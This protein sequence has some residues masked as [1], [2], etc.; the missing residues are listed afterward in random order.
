[1]IVQTFFARRQSLRGVVLLC[2]LAG[3]AANAGSAPA[4]SSTPA[5][6]SDGG[7]VV[8]TADRLSVQ[9][10]IDRKVYT[11]AADLQSITGTVADVLQAVPSIELDIDGNL[12]L[13]GDSNVTVLVD[14]RPV[15]SLAGSSAADAL[16][17][18]PAQDIERIEVITNP[19]AQFKA[20][21]TAGI[22]NIV[23]KKARKDGHSGGLQAN[24]GNAH[25]WNAAANGSVTQ[26]RFTLSG[27]ASFREDVRERI[28]T[29]SRS[30]VVPQTGAIVQSGESLDETM[31]RQL[32]SLRGSIEFAI[33][34]THKLSFSATRGE[35][36]GR[37]FFDQYNTSG[38]DADLSSDTLRHSDGLEWSI[39][40]SQTLNYEQT[41]ARPEEKLT[42]SIGRTA[43]HER[44]SYLYT[45]TDLLSALPVTH[46]TLES[47]SDKIVYL[48]NVDYVL[49][50]SSH[51]K[52]KT[53]YALEDNHNGSDNGGDLEDP[54][55]GALLPNPLITNHFRYRQT[56]HAVYG[57][58]ESP[59]GAWTLLGGLRF[60]HT[61]VDISPYD[62]SPPTSFG[63][64]RPFPSL[65]I[66]RPVSDEATVSLS[67]SRRITRPDGYA[68]DPHV[69]RQDIHNLRAGNPLLRPQD[70]K[71]YE[72]AYAVDH[73]G[74]SYSVTGYWRDTHDSYTGITVPID[75]Q[76]TL[77]TLTNLPHSRSGGMEFTANGHLMPRLGYNLSGNAFYNEIDATA[78]GFTGLKSTTGVNAKLSLDFKATVTDAAQVALSRRDRFLTPQGYYAAVMQ[79]NV[80]YRHTFSKELAAV[81][82]VTDLFNQQKWKRYVDTPTLMDVYDRHAV[83][84]V[85]YVGFVYTIGAPKKS[86][87][88]GFDYDTGGG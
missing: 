46:D 11:I 88:S 41:F 45:N 22:I 4:P 43:F 36:Q 61:T 59:L 47:G 29:D 70:T 71:S 33:D 57:T 65:H 23:T 78:L 31:H 80:G 9:T 8:V 3:A 32:P 28:A 24:V 84:R 2:G 83:G 72:V 25:R 60:E 81:V 10:L 58:L 66:E 62:S 27:N 87:G 48:A 18:I 12:S 54:T 82:T 1:M 17:Q 86:R 52:F 40:T 37:R 67:A 20:E 6:P 68:L 53:G 34:K 42:G 64:A 30:L 74:S 63:Y 73:R 15:A 56:V 55:T 44:E 85:A 50:F 77:T 39:D 16:A 75:A 19:P 26:G 7:A 49:P 14:G 21:G 38:M 5:A 51:R 76:T 69:D 79:V 35:R 13:R